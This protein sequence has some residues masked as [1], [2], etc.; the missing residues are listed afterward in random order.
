MV[1]PQV[2]NRQRVLRGGGQ[3]PGA[4][5]TIER[6]V[7]DEVQQMTTGGQKHER[8]WIGGE[9]ISGCQGK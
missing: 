3:D 8:R 2:R 1:L 5:D 4:I 6:A 7:W 9:M